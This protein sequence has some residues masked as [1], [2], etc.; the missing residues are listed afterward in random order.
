MKSLFN[1]M[2]WI[3]VVSCLMLPAISHA[4]CSGLY[5]H[6]FTT[7]QGDKVNLCEHQHQAILVV[8]TA[9]KCGFTPQFEKLESMY[10]KYKDK[11]LL[12]VGFPSN[13]FRQEPASNKE[14]GDFCKLT[15]AV[16][17]PM[18][19][20]TSVVGPQANPLYQQ[21]T[22]MTQQPPMWNFYKYLILP[23]GKQV[24]V[25]SSDVEPESHEVMRRLK[26][27]LK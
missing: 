8:N 22:G 14:I 2:A 25:Y 13:D 18:M 12:V 11:G 17:F 21:L 26:P 6:Q 7:L 16:K 24:Y 3:G 23:G 5:N 1:P 20:K 9:S 10:S 19:E 15:Y 4:A 27:H